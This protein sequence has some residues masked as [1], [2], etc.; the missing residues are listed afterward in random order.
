MGSSLD[1]QEAEQDLGRE[2]LDPSSPGTTWDPKQ[3]LLQLL[4]DSWA[5]PGAERAWG[6][7][8]HR[9]HLDNSVIRPRSPGELWLRQ[10]SVSRGL[11]SKHG[12]DPRSR[13]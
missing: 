6:R 5:A 8:P 4:A 1:Q 11:R 7:A 9:Q 3:G 12:L 13:S 10:R 2:N